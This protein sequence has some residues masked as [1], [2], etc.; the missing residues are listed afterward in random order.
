MYS[1]THK[2]VEYE[3]NIL[4]KLMCIFDVVTKQLVF[5]VAWKSAYSRAAV[6]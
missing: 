3:S 6:V 1:G 4:A 5:P 2:T